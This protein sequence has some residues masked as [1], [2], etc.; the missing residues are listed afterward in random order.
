MRRRGIPS[1]PLSGFRRTF[2]NCRREAVVILAAW[3]F[4]LVWTIGSAA[5]LGYG[6]PPDQ[7]GTLLG[8]PEWA[9]WG[10]LTP[11]IGATVFSVLFGLLSVSEDDLGETASEADDGEE[12][13]LR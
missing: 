10:V 12:G 4:F 3:G 5:L 2:L 1:K 6:T 13:E 7:E 9:F 11:W 8:I